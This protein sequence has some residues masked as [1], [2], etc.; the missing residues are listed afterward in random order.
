MFK[1]YALPNIVFLHIWTGVYVS[2]DASFKRQEICL[3]RQVELNT[4]Y[5]KLQY[6]III[7]SAKLI[8]LEQ[9]S[10]QW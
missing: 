3:Q 6:G 4:Q 9:H 10:A 1:M 7:L 5:P 8:I 2:K